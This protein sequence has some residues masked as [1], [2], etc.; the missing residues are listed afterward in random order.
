MNPSACAALARPKAVPRREAV[1]LNAIN[2]LV[3][4]VMAD[5]SMDSSA[6]TN[7]YT[8]VVVLKASST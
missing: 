5:W 4:G 7:T 8:A 6:N 2:V 3:V 1:T